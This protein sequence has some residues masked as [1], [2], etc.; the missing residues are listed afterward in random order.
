[1][2]VEMQGEGSFN[3][4]CD[5]LDCFYCKFMRAPVPKDGVILKP[6][7]ATA[8][9][10]KNIPWSQRELDLLLKNIDIPTKMLAHLLRRHTVRGI[11]TKK[12][13]LRRR[14]DIPARGRWAPIPLQPIQY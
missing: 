13:E 10:S 5:D 7:Y 12:F 3:Y 11:H 6:I 14:Y 2:N 4:D 1:M 8:F 9:N